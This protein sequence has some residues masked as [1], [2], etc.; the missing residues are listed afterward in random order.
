MTKLNRHQRLALEVVARH[1]GR[2][3]GLP[4]NG[5]SWSL[6]RTRQEKHRLDRKTRRRTV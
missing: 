6:Y 4:K 2:S 1:P 3:D 5:T